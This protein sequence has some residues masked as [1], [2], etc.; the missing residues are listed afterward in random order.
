M[1]STHVLIEVRITHRLP[2]EVDAQTIADLAAHGVTSAIS[3]DENLA[4]ATATVAG[5]SREGVWVEGYMAGS[6]DAGENILWRMRNG[7]AQR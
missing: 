2:L 1:A 7:L 4:L 3:T 6:K 5:E